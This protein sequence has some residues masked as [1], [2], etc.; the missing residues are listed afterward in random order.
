MQRYA[1]RVAPAIALGVA[2]FIA[3]T[4]PMASGQPAKRAI[5]LD[6]L[7]KFKTVGEPQRS[8]DG[9]W[10]AYVVESTDVEKDKRDSDL[11]MV[12]WDGT[13]TVR[14]TSGPE[15]ESSPRWSPDGRYLAFLASRGTE[16]EK[17][18][19]SQIWLLDRLGGEAQKLTEVDGGV[20]DYSWSPD[21][22]TFAFTT[23]DKDPADAPEK[24]EGWKR[25]TAPPIVTDRY[26]F[27]QDRDGYLKRFYTHVCVFDIATKKVEQITR[28]Q[29][30]DASPAWSP[31]GKR[32][33]FVSARQGPDPDR[34]QNSDI[35]VV[36][37]KAG[38]EPKQLTTFVGSDSGRPAWSPDG[39]WIAYYQ[40]D[41]TRY[42]PYEINKVA[43]IPAA[44][45]AAKVLTEALDRP[46]FRPDLVVAGRQDAHIRRRRRPRR[47]RR[48]DD[49]GGRCRREADDRPARRSGTCRSALDGNL[50]LLAGIDV[51]DARGVRARGRHT[52]QA[53]E[54]ERRPAGPA[55]ARY[56]RRLHVDEQGR[57]GGEWA[58]REARVVHTRQE[59]PDAAHHP[60]RPQRAGRPLLQLRQ[61]VLRGARLR[62]AEHQ[63]PRQLGPRPGVP[64]GHLRRLGQQGSGGSASARSTRPWHQASPTPI[65]SASAAGATAAS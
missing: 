1:R 40:G 7:A 59:V 50:T 23:S 54:G 28:G 45:G 12:S 53:H 56:D 13:Q 11:W 52:A 26:H 48:A 37:A 24:M 64:E 41:E 27:K 6:D 58:H 21:S 35:Y 63:L 34:H 17:K 29:F 25:K 8:P 60:R 20:S 49:N 5:T 36:E 46:G 18:K 33:A 16:D 65:A 55:P 3:F 39:Q 15:S 14:L 9:K 47:V 31:D 4:P 62:G 19:G 30:E 32:I 22:K 10:V 44:G 42:N 2:L 43:I 57:H 51:P 61:R 38:A